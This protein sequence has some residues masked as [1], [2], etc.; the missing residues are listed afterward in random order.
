MIAMPG[1]FQK[2]AMKRVLLAPLAGMALRTDKGSA[3][4]AQLGSTR[5]TGAAYIV[6]IARGAPIKRRKDKDGALLA[7]TGPSRTSMGHRSVRLARRG[8]S[9]RT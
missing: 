8:G 5:L 3:R 7:R 1:P 2:V 4:C 6:T 9:W